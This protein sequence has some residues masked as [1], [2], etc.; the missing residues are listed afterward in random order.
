MSKKH[1]PKQHKQRY[2]YVFWSIATF[3]VL[4]GQIAVVKT[5]NRLSNNLELVI[6]EQARQKTNKTAF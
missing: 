4:L 5:Y 1:A 6:I 2:Y 3:S